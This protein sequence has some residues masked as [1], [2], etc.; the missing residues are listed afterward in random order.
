MKILVIE[1]DK[2]ITEVI[3]ITLEMLAGCP[4][5]YY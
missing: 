1:D 3:R 2:E 4:A 5:G